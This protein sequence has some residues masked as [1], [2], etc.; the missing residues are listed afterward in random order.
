[1]VIQKQKEHRVIKVIILVFF[2]VN[3]MNMGSQEKV[4]GKYIS[5]DGSGTHYASYSFDEKGIFNFEE[6]GHLGIESLGK[7]HYRIDNDSLILN[8]DLT[9]LEDESYYM[10][11]KYNNSNDSIQIDLTVKDFENVTIENVMVFTIPNGQSKN[12]D[13]DGKVNLKFKKGS[14]TDK[15]QVFVDGEYWAECTIILRADTNYI[16]DVFM[17]KIEA[18]GLGHPKAIKGEIEKYKILKFSDTSMTLENNDRT[19]IWNKH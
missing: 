15:I 14:R 19:L 12:I 17:N 1:M 6:G 11:K 8:Y 18:F 3:F 9:E 16:I 10:S 2:L 4:V 7:G 5:K 13:K